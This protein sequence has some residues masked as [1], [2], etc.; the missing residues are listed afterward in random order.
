MT[1]EKAHRFPARLRNNSGENLFA[2]AHGQQ[3][4]EYGVAERRQCARNARCQATPHEG[5]FP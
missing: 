1:F 2:A 3:Y 5:I 4:S